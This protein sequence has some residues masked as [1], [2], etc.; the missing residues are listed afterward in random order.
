MAIERMCNSPAGPAFARPVIG[1]G[2]GKQHGLDVRQVRPTAAKRVA[3]CRGPRPASIRKPKIHRCAR[4]C[5]LPALP[6][7][8]PQTASHSSS[9]FLVVHRRQAWGDRFFCAAEHEAVEGQRPRTQQHP[10]PRT[11]Q[12][13]RNYTQSRPGAVKPFGKCTVAMA[14]ARDASPRPPAG[15]RTR[16]RRCRPAIRHTK[17]QSARGTGN[18]RGR[19]VVPVGPQLF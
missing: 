11:S 15:S 9:L 18:E 8:R 4:N 5:T 1:V 17:P 16:P 12:S 3:S 14:P 19:G 10:P 7:A 2:M 13:T 6:L